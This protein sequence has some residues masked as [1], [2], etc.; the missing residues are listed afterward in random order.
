[1]NILE[2]LRTGLQVGNWECIAEAYYGLTGENLEIPEIEPEDATSSMLKEMMQRLDKIEGQSSSTKKSKKATAKKLKVNDAVSEDF[3]V[4]SKKASRK[5]TDRTREN[6]FDSM[7]DAIQ[8]AGK[9]QY[10]DRIDDKVK[11][12][13]RSRKAY[14]TK[15]VTCGECRATSEVNPVF[16]RDNYVCDKC[17]QRRG[18]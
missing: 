15:T 5:V 17:L 11:P 8:E 4:K 7:Q 12:S 2:L 3:S 1:M 18:R 6:K 13:K 14:S 10:Y 16:A 9:E